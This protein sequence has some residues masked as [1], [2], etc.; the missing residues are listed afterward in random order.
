MMERERGKIAGVGVFAAAMGYLEA[1]VV[2]YLRMLYCPNGFGFPLE[3]FMGP[4]VLRVEAFRELS[5]LVMLLSVAFLAGL[6]FKNRF[7]YF[8][9]AF[10]VW[11][12]SYYV[13]LKATLNWPGSWLTDDLLFLIPWAWVG[14]VLAPVIAS[15]TMILLAFVLLRSEK[16]LGPKGPEPGV[17]ALLITGGS[18]QLY[19]Y[20]ADYGRLILGGN[21]LK[22]LLDYSMNEGFQ[23]V[24]SSYIPGDFG[25]TLFCAGETMILAGIFMF[26]R[27]SRA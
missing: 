11:D 15:L 12:L 25:W 26:W 16:N 7:A 17:W 2:V 8:L 24:L 4:D 14:P 22:D 9:L 18:L 3:K 6:N 21:H 19:T 10:A 13:G 5:T 23:K 27:E 1:A 20:L